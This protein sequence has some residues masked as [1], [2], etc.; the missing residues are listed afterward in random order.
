[1][2]LGITVIRVIIDHQIPLIQTEEVAIGCAMMDTK[3]EM[4]VANLR[5]RTAI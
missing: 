4:D 2:N 1:M 5:S 3:R